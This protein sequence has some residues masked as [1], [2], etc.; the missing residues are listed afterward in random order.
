MMNDLAQKDLRHYKK[1][2]IY[3]S[4]S[5]LSL[6]LMSLCFTWLFNF[7]Y[8]FKPLCGGFI[9]CLV[10]LVNVALLA[11]GFYGVAIKQS[12]LLVLGPML[13]FIAMILL[14]GIFS[15]YYQEYLLGF[16]LGLTSPLMIGLIL[17]IKKPA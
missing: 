15:I 13:S 5:I 8:L 4:L 6:L 16:A 11:I 2:F 10:A 17:I 3:T 1:I 9:G 12:R 14:T 7:D